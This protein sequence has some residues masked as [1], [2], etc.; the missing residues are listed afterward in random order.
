MANWH[1]CDAV[2]MG[3]SRRVSREWLLGLHPWR[4]LTKLGLRRPNDT[5]GKCCS[6]FLQLWLDRASQLS[7]L[8]SRPGSLDPQRQPSV[9]VTVDL[10]SIGFYNRHALFNILNGSL[11]RGRLGTYRVSPVGFTFKS[12]SDGK[13]QAQR[14]ELGIRHYVERFT[15]SNDC[16]VRT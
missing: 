14:F 16:I 6:T 12:L 5:T 4:R 9:I 3:W 10:A 13:L 2:A 1:V 7:V 11:N 8:I 15:N